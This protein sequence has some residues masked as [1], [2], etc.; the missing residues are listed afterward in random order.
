M[1][2]RDAF[3]KPFEPSQIE[4][5]LRDYWENKKFYRATRKPGK[6]PY[7]IVMPPPNV[8]GDLTM[9]HV[10]NNTLQDS[11]VRLNRAN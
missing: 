2:R 6:T 9:G 3:E 10:L 1:A 4:K 5:N 11:L 7:T 8:T